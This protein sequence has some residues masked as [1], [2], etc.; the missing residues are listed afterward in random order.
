L[1]FGCGKA[2]RHAGEGAHSILLRAGPRHTLKKEE[3]M[4]RKLIVTLFISISVSAHATIFGSVRGIVH[5]PH[6][7]PVS[8]AMVTLR[9]QTSDL[10]KTA[11]TD[12]NGEFQFNGVPL[13]DY[14]ISVVA[15]D[16]SQVE[17]KL[18]VQAGT[19]PVLH[20]ELRIAA[21]GAD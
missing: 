13:G 6:H 8:G 17:Q 11:N 21:N 9:S 20:F 14:S 15:P 12:N 16:F 3:N 1:V 19:E 7:R 4:I 10:E 5:D 2:R 18:V